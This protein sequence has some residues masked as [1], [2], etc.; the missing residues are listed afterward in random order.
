ME[1]AV[2]RLVR[3]IATG[4]SVAI[5]GDFDA[6]GITATALLW[7]GLGRY[8]PGDRLIYYIP[9]RFRESHGISRQG[10]EQLQ[11]RCSLL[12]TCDTGSSN[13]EEL[14]LAASMGM[15]VI[16][17]DHHTLPPQRPP[18]VAIVNPRSLPPEHPFATLSGVAVAYT[19]LRAL[20][21][22]LGA[23]L[24]DLEE[25]LDLVAVGLVADL[26]QLVGETRYLAQRGLAVLRHKRRPGLR[27]LLDACRKTGD[28]A[29]DIGFGIAPRL[30]AI[31]R[32]WGDV[33]QCVTLL[34]SRDETE[35][36]QLV[37]AAERAN[38]LRQELQ[39]ELW[40]EVQQLIVGLDL[41]TTGVVVLAS[42]QWPAGILGIVAGQA[43]QTYGRPTFLLTIEEDVAKGSGR[44]PAGVDLYALLAGQEDLILRFGGHP[45]A[46]GLHVMA[47]RLPLLRAALNQR[48]WQHYGDR[49]PQ[50]DCII[51]L[52]V[53]VSDLGA[54]LFR[55]LS[56][57]EPYGMGNPLPKLLIRRALFGQVTEDRLPEVRGRRPNLRKVSFNLSDSSGSI[58][59][60]WWHKRYFDLP[61]GACDVVV[62]L[63]DNPYRRRYEVR[64][65]D[66]LAHGPTLTQPWDFAPPSPLAGDA[67][68]C[69]VCPSTLAAVD[70]LRAQRR[71]IVLNYPPPETCHGEAMWHR[72]RELALP[73]TPDQVASALHLSD[74]HLIDLAIQ[75]RLG[76]AD[77]EPSRLIAA[78][79]E[80]YF[81]QRFFDRQLR[82]MG[83]SLSTH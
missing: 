67:Y 39:A 42:P 1:W 59:G 19:L 69:D 34:T 31:S 79:D 37:D 56:Q 12:V 64:V 30:N 57:L 2:A 33:R 77:T 66:A 52:E 24:A 25:L 5:W 70:T 45:F 71:P 32:I 15:E 8:L 16:V 55:E 61:Q 10:L 6:D 80:H 38:Q 48:Y 43:V 78:L 23:P 11:G 3:A 46:A 81:Q 7:E 62:E 26:V 63:V 72:L 74:H 17:T 82:Q 51:D 76:A 58:P 47:E 49:P 20:T 29:T 28:R 21:E 4:E 14:T 41:T 36:Q 22:A 73:L 18:V 35:C 9:D 54:E 50:P 27:L 40:Q 75:T 65:V 68:L 44:S 53:K 83:Y 13:E 60:H